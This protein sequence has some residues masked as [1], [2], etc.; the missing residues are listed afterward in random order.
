[1]ALIIA[2]L[3]QQGV[4]GVRKMSNVFC[5]LQLDNSYCQIPDELF[6]WTC[7]VDF[8]HGDSLTSVLF[9]RFTL[10][11]EHALKEVRPTL[12]R[13]TTPFEVAIP[14]EVAYANDVDFIGQTYVDIKNIQEVLRKPKDYPANSVQQRPR[15]DSTPNQTTPKQRSARNHRTS[16]GQKSLGGGGIR[17]IDRESSR[18]VTD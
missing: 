8:S 13:P 17:I 10:Y 9:S 3:T 15:T 18:I 6:I 12:P 1:M 14:N 16:T 5:V 7:H 2:T 11:L 4:G